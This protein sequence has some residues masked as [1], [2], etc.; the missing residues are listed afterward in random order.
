MNQK[1]IIDKDPT[2]GLQITL[3]RKEVDVLS[4]DEVTNVCQTVI[5]PKH[6]NI[7]GYVGIGLFAGIRSKEL[8]QLQWEA[9]DLDHQHIVVS[10]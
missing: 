10:A 7:R 5:D 6:E 3:E 1:E 9:I 8:T 4:I 2:Q